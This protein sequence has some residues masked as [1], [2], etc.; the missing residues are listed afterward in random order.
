MLAIL[1]THPIQYQVP[2]WQALARDGRVPFEV[3]YLT[4]H[5]SQASLDREFGK[6][7]AWDLDLLSGYRHRFLE[8]APAATPS[9]FWRCRLR[10]SLRHRLR[11]GGITCLWIQ[12]WQVAAYWQAVREAKA[13]GIDLWLRGES[14][15]LSQVSLWKRPVKRLLLGW[16]FRRVDQFLCIGSANT[17]LYRDFNIPELKLHLAPYSVDN[18]RFFRQANALRAQRAELR[19]QWKVPAGSFCVL[20]CGKFIR[21]KRPMDLVQAALGLIQDGRLPAVHILFVGSGELGQQLRD[22]CRVVFD[23]ERPVPTGGY[24]G[25]ERPPA[26]FAGFLNQRDISRAYV[27]ADCLVLPSDTGETWGLVANEA[28]ASGLPCAISDACG[29]A[30]DLLPG[31]VGK[32]RFIAGNIN[33]L[34]SSILALARLAPGKGELQAVVGRFHLDETVEA[35]ARLFSAGRASHAEDPPLGL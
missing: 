18:D 29:C 6:A 34:S 33:S 14:N 8:V 26:S 12:G 13:L 5:G 32:G 23:A 17:R 16:L 25:P 9:D 20:F 30:E 35:V 28:M 2:V 21:K 10:E 7:F 31:P 19:R 1:A 15:D 22:S 24:L 27:A 11:A 3:W 4:D